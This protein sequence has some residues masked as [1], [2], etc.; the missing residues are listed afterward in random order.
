[1]C[2]VLEEGT[3]ELREGLRELVDAQRTLI[4]KP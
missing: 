4:P 2:A 3:N 1:V